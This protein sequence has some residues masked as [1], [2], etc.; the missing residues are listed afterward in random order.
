MFGGQAESIASV[1]RSE[2]E[3]AAPQD[4]GGVPGMPPSWVPRLQIGR[5]SLD[6]RCPRGIKTVLYHKCQHEIFALFGECSRWDGMVEKLTLYE[7]G[8]RTV[9]LC[10]GMLCCAVVCCA[11]LCNAVLCWARLG[12]AGLGCAGLG[13]AGLGCGQMLTCGLRAG[14]FVLSWLLFACYAVQYCAVGQ[15]RCCM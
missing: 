2:A 13:C 1:A 3:E 14:G 6:M 15:F 8:H 11:V 5:D 9:L 12:W 4:T 7:V 10:C